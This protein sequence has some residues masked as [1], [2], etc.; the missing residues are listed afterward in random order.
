MMIESWVG[1]TARLL[2]SAIKKLGHEYTFVT[3]NPGHYGSAGGS[4]HPVVAGAKKTLVT[5]TNDIESLCNV[6]EEAHQHNAFDAALTICDYYIETVTQA[7][8]RL[9]VSHPFPKNPEIARR[10]DQVRKALERHGI[11]NPVY[12]IVYSGKAAI[13]AGSDIGYPLVVKPTDLASSAFVRMV[14]NEEEL[15]EAC[16]AIME[17]ETNFR[18]QKRNTACLIEEY[19]NGEEISVEAITINGNTTIIGITDKSITGAPFFIEDGHMFPAQLAEKVE[20]EA[21]QLVAEAL[22]AIG[23]DNGISH[24]EVKLTEYGP[25]IVEI[26][27]RPAGNY[28]SELIEHVTGNGLVDAFVRLAVGEKPSISLGQEGSGSAAIKFLIPHHGGVVKSI[29][30]IKTLE[31][32]ANVTRWKLDTEVGEKVSDPIDNACYIGHLVA[33]DPNG[34]AARAIAENAVES[35][36]IEVSTSEKE[37]VN[38]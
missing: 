11:A 24:T 6:L 32:N 31:N 10:K 22:E 5:E 2:P 28:I 8:T 21:L 20:S 19:M 37:E 9:Q 17:F 14:H 1:G 38:E 18:G 15:K 29:S 3:R 12:R 33:V 26:N 36:K 4:D 27:P 7:A 13:L 35:L 25:R 16:K 34:S 30:G 23:F